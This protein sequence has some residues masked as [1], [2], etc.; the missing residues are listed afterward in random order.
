MAQYH[1]K[2]K[3]TFEKDSRVTEETTASGAKTMGMSFDMSD[4]KD[5]FV[6][7]KNQ[8]WMEKV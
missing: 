5:A 1:S 8:K 6:N 4:E 3:S 7:H 2:R